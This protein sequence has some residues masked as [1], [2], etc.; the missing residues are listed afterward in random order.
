MVNLAALKLDD[1]CRVKKDVTEKPQLRV[2]DR[3]PPPEILW[4]TIGGGTRTNAEQKVHVKA[5]VYH[6]LGFRRAMKGGVIGAFH[7][8]QSQCPRGC[9]SLDEHS[10]IR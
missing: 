9:V 1:T 2:L 3:E 10:P 7:C 5:H 4:K 8:R 6:T